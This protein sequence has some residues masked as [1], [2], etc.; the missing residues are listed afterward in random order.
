VYAASLERC[1]RT[2]VDAICAERDFYSRKD[3]VGADES[4]HEIEGSYAAL[5]R[6]ISVAPLPND[7][8]TD[9]LLRLF[10]LYIRNP[11][12]RNESNSERVDALNPVHYAFFWSELAGISN[13]ANPADLEALH[14]TIQ[15]RWELHVVKSAGDPLI[16]S[17]NPV[18]LVGVG[19]SLLFALLP[20]APHHALVAANRN[21]VWISSSLIPHDEVALL[22]SLQ[23]RTCNR[24]VYAN[25]DLTPDLPMI[26][27]MVGTPGPSFGRIG[28]GSFTVQY[29]QY[30]ADEL[31]FVNLR[32]GYRLE[33][34]RT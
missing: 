2:N 6:K 8:R 5:I 28:A 13:P 26:R 30:T 17:D 33:D 21:A 24:Q 18:K 27:S 23:V 34:R 1:W 3:P 31:S 22:N 16:T 10:H 7:D 32:P 9:L 4:F 14:R 29:H 12:L 25:H 11:L 20:I 19:R 15:E